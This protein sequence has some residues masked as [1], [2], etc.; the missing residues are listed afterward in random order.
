MTC[1]IVSDG[2]CGSPVLTE[3]A[4][5]GRFGTVPQTYVATAVAR[6][7]MAADRASPWRQRL[8]GR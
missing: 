7:I 4:S 3:A 5:S 6:I 8:A 1:L 2:A